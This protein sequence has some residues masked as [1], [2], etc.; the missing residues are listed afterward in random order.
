MATPHVAGTVAL[1][2]SRNPALRGDI[3]AIRSILDDTA[4]NAGTLTCGGTADDNDVFGEGRLNALAAVKAA[5]LSRGRSSISPAPGAG[6]R[7]VPNRFEPGS[8]T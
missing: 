7:P 4:T 8:R 5:G 1:I 6:A 2:I 3:N